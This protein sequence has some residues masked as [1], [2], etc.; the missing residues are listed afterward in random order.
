MILGRTKNFWKTQNSPHNLTS[1]SLSFTCQVWIVILHGA[2][3]RMKWDKGLHS[4][5]HIDGI[6][7]MLVPSKGGD[8]WWSILCSPINNPLDPA[9]KICCCG[10]HFVC[11]VTQRMTLGEEVPIRTGAIYSK[12]VL[13]FCCVPQVAVSQKRLPTFTGNI[14]KCLSNTDAVA[15]V[16]SL[17]PGWQVTWHRGDHLI[18]MQSNGMNPDWESGHWVWDL[19]TYELCNLRQKPSLLWTSGSSSVKQGMISLSPASLT[20]LIS[21]TH[22]FPSTAGK[23]ECPDVCT[24]THTHTLARTVHTCMLLDP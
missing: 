5:W 1:A 13:L 14:E 17:F 20:T 6:Q 4:A 15:A 22:S 11:Y 7:Q 16:F 8:C 12:H 3:L 19:A 23:D 24:T 10:I 21:S 2:V 9:G 18:P